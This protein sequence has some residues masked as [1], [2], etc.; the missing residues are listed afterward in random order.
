[1]GEATK[2]DELAARIWATLT[3]DGTMKGLIDGSDACRDGVMDALCLDAFPP[4]HC[5]DQ[6]TCKFACRNLNYC[7]GEA[8]QIDC[9][10]YCHMENLDCKAPAP[11]DCGPSGSRSGLVVL[12]LL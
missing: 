6:S 9:D 2:R 8:A 12:V 5:D 1:M 4:C 11:Q 10:S 3:E 7:L